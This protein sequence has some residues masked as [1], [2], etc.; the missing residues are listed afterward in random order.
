MTS[1]Q[2]IWNIGGSA[3]V[4]NKKFLFDKRWCARWL[5]SELPKSDNPRNMKSDSIYKSRQVHTCASRDLGLF[6]TDKSFSLPTYIFFRRL[7]PMVVY[8]SVSFDDVF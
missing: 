1:L 2:S 6:E 7:L 4:K 3:A 8:N 5:F